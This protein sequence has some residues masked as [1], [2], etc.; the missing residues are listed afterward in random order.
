MTNH[1]GIHQ[2]W[3]GLELEGMPHFEQAMQRVYA[4]FEHAIIDRP[5][6]RFLSYYSFRDEI[7]K[8]VESKS[9]AEKKDWWFDV[10]RQVDLF[11]NYIT[12]HQFHGETFPVYFPNL[13]P[14]V[15]P[16]FY[17][18]ELEFG[19]KTSWSV[20]LVENWEDVDQIKLDMSNE[21]FRKIEELT[22]YALERC[23][24]KF[25]VG[26]TDLHPGLDCVAAWR[27]PQQLCLDMIEAPDHVMHLIERSIADLE[28]IYDHFDTM[29]KAAGQLSVGWMGVPSFGRMH[30]P[31]CDFSSMIS[32][33]FFR[34]FGLSILE[35]EVKTMTHNIFHVDGKGVARHLDAILSVPEVHAVEWVQGVGDDLPIMQWVPF[36]K[37]L[38]AKQVSVIVELD[39]AEVD[40]FM[41]EVDPHGVFLFVTTENEVEEDEILKRV[42]KWV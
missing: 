11:E 32:P 25:M 26:Y 7:I 18:A 34:K 42:A 33:R 15:Y 5:P 19:D 14:D 9:P 17:G 28:Q 39:R 21:Y 31:S 30:Y 37:E 1:N 23:S 3:W 40:G 4:W 27:D 12:G 6:V 2:D 24:G 16:A 10:E 29:L 38:Q 22:Q 20:P 36:I 35:R 41:A 13:G 8:E